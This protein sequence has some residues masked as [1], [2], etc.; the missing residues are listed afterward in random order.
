MSRAPVLCGGAPRREPRFQ[1]GGVGRTQRSL[2]P[3]GSLRARQQPPLPLPASPEPG[4]PPS[5]QPPF[6]SG[7][8]ARPPPAVTCLR[9]PPSKRVPCTPLSPGSDSRL[10]PDL[11]SYFLPAQAS[12]PTLPSPPPP[13]TCHRAPAGSLSKSAQ[14]TAGPPLRG[15][16]GSPAHL[17]RSSAHV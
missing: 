10:L 3:R 11:R 15:A 6:P 5:R 2:V 8:A 1:E 16:H 13:R 4:G 9:P 14:L 12:R 7:P 17:T